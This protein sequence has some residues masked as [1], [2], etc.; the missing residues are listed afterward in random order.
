MKLLALDDLRENLQ[1][2]RR[3]ER[4]LRHC[5]NSQTRRKFQVLKQLTTSCPA[6]YTRL[7]GTEGLDLAKHIV[8]R[9]SRSVYSRKRKLVHVLHGRNRLPIQRD[10][11]EG[12]AVES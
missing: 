9:A 6:W 10:V 12:S 4:R 1:G 2:S 7:F 8:S 3:L 5:S 11:R